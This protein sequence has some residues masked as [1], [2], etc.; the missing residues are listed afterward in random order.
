[1]KLQDLSP[2]T[3]VAIGLGLRMAMI[4]WGTVQDANSNVAYT[5][6]DYH[7]FT[8]AA[9]HL[10]DGCP[11]DKIALQ[12]PG[13]EFEELS[14]PS[15]ANGGCAQGILPATGRLVLQMEDDLLDMTKSAP[16]TFASD[17]QRTEPRQDFLA[18]MVPKVMFLVKPAF[19]F[20]AG[21]GNPYK[22][23][24]YRYTPLLAVLLSP[25]HLLADY[26][27]VPQQ[28][29]EALFGK[30][31]FVLADVLIALLLW[32]IMDIRSRSHRSGKASKRDGW[33]VGLIWLA[34]PFAAQISTRGSSESIL[35]FL[36]LAFVDVTLRAYPESNLP[37][38][39]AAS[40]PPLED[41]SMQKVTLDVGY[42]ADPAPWS[43]ERVL[44]PFLF[45]LAIHWKLYPI[46]YAAALVPH[47]AN[48]KAGRSVLRF[49]ATSVYFLT[50]ITCLTF[51]IWGTPFIQETLLYHVRRSDHR[52]NFSPFFLPAYL[53]SSLSAHAGTEWVDTLKTLQPLFGF[54]P[55][56]AATAYI[57]FAV[58][59]K[60][61]I[62]ALTLQ[63]MAFVALNKVCT[64][65]YF[66]WFIWFLP[67]LAPHL[68]FSGGKREI[69]ALTVIWVG[70]Q[71]I[72]LSQA[73]LLEFKAMDTYV[74]TWLAS[75]LLL[76]VHAFIIVRLTRAWSRAR[77]E[78]E[79]LL[80]KHQEEA[81]KI[82][83]DKPEASKAR[84]TM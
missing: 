57:G 10:Y 53:T 59:G 20:V 27:I 30:L 82:V 6:I 60:D 74:R 61:L 47:L 34:N 39:V 70:A 35:G 11:I 55:Q 81:K 31:L 12:E 52:H 84:R 33:L 40:L 56:L 80:R 42:N 23:D 14:N 66:M 68:S 73:F 71:A 54:V 17:A 64:S 75:L 29:A 32:D 28:Q 4:G 26:G 45:A 46:I 22:R 58:G 15:I 44:A 50:V 37:T 76:F 77:V 1:M 83:E 2:A 25:A 63:T 13:E 62:A 36:V 3:W 24:T 9:A 41:K 19:R 65:Q 38:V 21:I 8:S 69:V 72:W 48:A 67:L 79:S 18:N 5:D 49:G 51:A 43:N 7:V 78:A 16:I